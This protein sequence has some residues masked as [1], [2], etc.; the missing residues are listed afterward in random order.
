M[1]FTAKRMVGWVAEVVDEDHACDQQHGGEDGGDGGG[2]RGIGGGAG[3][4]GT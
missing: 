3:G 4:A 1:A 2:V